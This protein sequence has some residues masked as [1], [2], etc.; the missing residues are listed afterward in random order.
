[1]IKPDINA[2]IGDIQQ[3]ISAS[4]PEYDVVIMPENMDSYVP[5]SQIGAVFVGFR[6]LDLGDSESSHAIIQFG[7][8][9]VQI[10]VMSYHVY[11]SN[12]A[13]D[14]VMQI[15]QALTGAIVDENRGDKSRVAGIEQIG[16]D[17]SKNIWVYDIDFRLPIFVSEE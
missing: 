5:N 10:T 15:V 2:I 9:M 13:L 1:M 17:A 3:R 8:M 16:F 11:G 7:E 6:W 14:V 4:A 12:G